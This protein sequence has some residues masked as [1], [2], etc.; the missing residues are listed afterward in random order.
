M[1]LPSILSRIFVFGFSLRFS[2]SNPYSFLHHS[3][4]HPS[5]DFPALSPSPHPTSIS[6]HHYLN[7]QPHPTHHLPSSTSQSVSP[8]PSQPASNHHHH[9]L[10]RQSFSHARPRHPPAN[11]AIFKPSENLIC[12]V[13]IANFQTN[14]AGTCWE[15]DMWRRRRRRGAVE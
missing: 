5:H 3:P 4:T 7:H 12:T 8:P 15:E 14:F 10:H 6:H 2:L 1:P 13:K 11:H 9:H